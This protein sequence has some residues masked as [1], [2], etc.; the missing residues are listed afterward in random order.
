M[1]HLNQ[2]GQREASLRCKAIIAACV[3][4]V[5]VTAISAQSAGPERHTLMQLTPKQMTQMMADHL[6]AEPMQ[7]LA[8]IAPTNFP[9][10]LSLLSLLPY[11]P[12]QRNQGAC[13]NCWAWAGTGVMEIA[14]NVQN[15]VASRLSVQLLNSCNPY[16]GC[17]AGG[18]LANVAQFYTYN[19]HAAPWNNPNG[20][21]T[22]GNGSCGTACGSIASAPQFPITSAS[23]TTIPTWGLSQGQAIANIKTTLKQ[24]KAVWFGFFMAS[25]A[26]W[27]NFDNFWSY[28]TESAQ[29]SN[30]N[31]GESGTTGG[32]HAVLCVGY[33]DTDPAGPTWIMVN[34]W[35]TTAG[36]PHGLFHV[37]Q[38]LDY[39]G[40][41][42]YG[43][44]QYYQLY[45]ETLNIQFAPQPSL[46]LA[47]TATNTAV[48]TWPSAAAGYTLQCRSTL[49]GAT[50][51]TV[52][53]TPALIN[54]Q[55]Q[56]I[57]PKSSANC[58]FRLMAP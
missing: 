39:S 30:F 56:V 11:I 49:N 25:D 42:T 4:A 33:D 29:W 2:I 23:V 22:S 51:S 31:A 19:G 20:P 53:N 57:L 10:S 26:D 48:L 8:V 16:V 38:N 40:T 21:W 55:F 27:V 6:Q 7:S 37:S 17:C 45:W 36:R 46:G 9:P 54:N 24:N 44:Q 12:A 43:P 13:G 50:W 35:G 3:T 58:F 32:G 41:Y 28:Q 15:G 18:W 5:G 34:S 47:L 14:H 1:K 52:P